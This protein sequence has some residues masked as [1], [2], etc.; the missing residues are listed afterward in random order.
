[1]TTPTTGDKPSPAIEPEKLRRAA[2][3]CIERLGVRED[4][5]VLVLCNAET[6][7]VAEAL[8]LAASRR[9]SDTE[10]LEF[11]AVSRHGEEPP[12]EVGEAMHRANVVFAPTL[13]SLS[14]T[15]A[16]VASSRGGTR[17]ASMPSINEE[18][19]ARAVAADYDQL[20]RGGRALAELLS[21]AR[22][23][24]ITTA[25]GGDV[26]LDLTG[27]V[28]LNDDGALWVP[29]MFGNLPA[30]EAYIA[31]VE[32]K[33]EGRIVFDASIAGHGRLKETL[34]V[35]LREGR[36]V[37][38][39]G[40]WADQ[41]LALLDS[42]GTN[43]RS[44]A[45]LGIGTNGAARICGNILED[46]KVK[47]TAHIAFGTSAGIGGVNQ[48]SVHLDGVFHL[49][50]IELDGTVV[51]SEGVFLPTESLPRDRGPQAGRRRTR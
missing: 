34:T 9:S 35:E 6:R 5:R 16:R 24:R 38:A 17:V 46:E 31:P 15:R 45:E 43:G 32:V 50:T 44:I 20:T 10:L 22:R 47:G 39:Q 19:F 21:Q 14:H 12:A 33:G 36:A 29:G 3:I 37:T 26:Q 51:V 7:A 41:L 8:H 1:M 49:P 42:G 18:I 40:E 13:Y 48:S 30:G 27:R 11:A 25:R 23:C 2:D 4:D 28:G